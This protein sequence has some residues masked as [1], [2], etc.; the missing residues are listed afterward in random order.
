MM[1]STAA[2]VI[3]STISLNAPSTIA[4]MTA[5]IT[6]PTK[7]HAQIPSL[8]TRV[9][10]TALVTGLRVATNWCVAATTSVGLVSE[11]GG[12]WS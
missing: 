1:A 8:G 11:I 10:R 9:G 3:G 2:N 5:A 12:G 7:H 6:T 4:T